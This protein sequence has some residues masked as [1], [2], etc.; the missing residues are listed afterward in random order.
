VDAGIWR[1][2]SLPFRLIKRVD[3]SAI[4]ATAAPSS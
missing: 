1:C 3:R 2:G 4:D